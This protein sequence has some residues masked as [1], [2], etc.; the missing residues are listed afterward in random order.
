MLQPQKVISQIGKLLFLI[1]QIKYILYCKAQI[2]N[3]KKNIYQ[4]IT[5]DLVQFHGAVID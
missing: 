1:L 5:I 4:L 2:G 3:E